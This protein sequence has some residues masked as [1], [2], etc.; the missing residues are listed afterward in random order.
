[1][2]KLQQIERIH[3]LFTTRRRRLTL[4]D[5]CT[6]LRIEPATCQALLVLMK[7]HLDS[8]IDYCAETGTYSYPDQACGRYKLPLCWLNPAEFIHLVELN[9]Q[10]NT[11]LPGLLHED[12]AEMS[13]G[14]NQALRKRKLSQYQFERRVKFLSDETPYNFPP[15]FSSI[16]A[17]LLDRRQ[18]AITVHADDGEVHSLNVCP[19]LLLHR[20]RSWQLTAWCHLHR[21]L[22]CF[23]I[24]R[25][26]SVSVLASRAREIAP[27]N[28]EVF[29]GNQFGY[30][31]KQ[32]LTLH[33]R[34][35]GDSAYQV[36]RQ[37]WHPDQKGEWQGEYYLLQLPLIDQDR[38]LTQVLSHLPNVQVLSPSQFAERLSAVLQ[39]ALVAQA[40]A[41]VVIQTKPKAKPV[42][43]SGTPDV[44]LD[45]ADIVSPAHLKKARAA[46]R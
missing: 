28:V 36:A 21:Q 44:E 5:L 2:N 41:P 20:N 32:P 16:C 13:D 24:A 7:E 39:Q 12:L 43:V 46:M 9:D 25:I 22:R 42:P 35:Q 10:L 31:Q 8:P 38:L 34:F 29:L 27:K 45:D 30:N 40:E 33:L 37:C 23:D 11:P 14:V 6:D 26:E 18:L 19:Q 17:G 3:Q 15:L 4:R 1:M